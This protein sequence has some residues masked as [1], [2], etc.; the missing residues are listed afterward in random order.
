MGG[1][2]K[3][4]LGVRH[5][6]YDS[7]NR[8]ST[9]RAM[10]A[11]QRPFMGAIPFA[12]GVTFRVWAPFASEVLVAGEFNSWSLT[13]TPLFSEDNGYWSADVPGAIVGQ[14]YKFV[15]SNSGQP[16]LW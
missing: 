12:G 14:Q 5:Q 2:G 3:V 7:R 8:H 16:P 10:P 4:K 6:N 13:S 15:I 1:E 9:G 11:S